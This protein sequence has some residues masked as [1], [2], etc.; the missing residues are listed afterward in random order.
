MG[1]HAART[2]STIAHVK[3]P[4]R[5]RAQTTTKMMSVSFVE[6]AATS[7]SPRLSW[8]GQGGI[9]GAA[10]AQKSSSTEEEESRPASARQDSDH[11]N[12][13]VGAKGP[14]GPPPA[15]DLKSA[16]THQPPAASD[17][18]SPG[19]N[20]WTLVQKRFNRLDRL[21]S[22]SL[23]IWG[24][25][26]DAD[27]GRLAALLRT[28][29]KCW[30]RGR[31][32]NRHMVVEFATK[33]AFSAKE[34]ATREACKAHGIKVAKSTRGWRLRRQHRPI[35]TR[36]AAKAKVPA[37]LPANRYTLIANAPTTLAEVRSVDWRRWEARRLM[38]PPPPRKPKT[39][40]EPKGRGDVRT[41][42][43]GRRKK[44]RPV[45]GSKRSRWRT[46]KAKLGGELAKN[47]TIRV[48][49][50]NVQGGMAR[51]I[52]EYEDF[53]TKNGYDVLAIQECKLAPS[54]KLAAK[55]F[56]V[57][58][59]EPEME[60]E[61]HGVLFL[62]ANHLATGVTREKSAVP[63]Q[64]WIRLTGTN[65]RKDM[66]ICSAYLPQERDAAEVR[67]HAFRALQESSKE[68]GEAGVVVVLGDLNAKIRG[69]QDAHEL[70]RMGGFCEPGKHTENGKLLMQVLLEARLVSLA[71]QSRP[72]AS[73][74]EG[75]EA[76]YWWT[77]R[78]PK[79]GILHTIDYVL[80]SEILAAGGT[81]F[82]VDYTDLNSD[83]HLVGALIECPRVLSRKRGRKTPRRRFKMDG[84]IQKSSSAADVEAA[85]KQRA[86][87]AESLGEAFTGFVLGPQRADLGDCADNGVC[88]GVGDFVSRI[89][90]AAEQ[91]VGSVE[92]GRKFSRS[93]FDDE[94]KQSIANR[95]AAHAV[96]RREGTPETWDEYERRRRA[97]NRMVK[98]KKRADWLKFEEQMEDAFHSDQRKMWQL[99]RR[100]VPSG[101]KAVVEPVLRKDGVLAK[102]EEQILE[103]WGDHQES[104][105]TP[106]PHELEDRAFGDLVCKQMR[107]AA[108]L[109]P[110]LPDTQVDREFEMEE[111]NRAVDNLDYHK[112]GTADGTVNTMF[113][114]GGEVM[115]K[116]L[117]YLFNWLRQRESIPADWQRSV[118][119][120]LFKEGDRADP[121]NYRGIALIS[122]LG[123]LYLSMWAARIAEHAE[124]RLGERQGGFRSRRSTV[125]Q[126]MTL[127][128][129]LL[130]RKRAGQDTYLCFVDFRKAF[131]T[132]WHEGLW[133]RM[134]DTGIRGK[135]WRVTRNLYSSIN[136]SVKLGDTT[137]RNVRMRQGVRQGCPL[138][139]T[140]FNLFVEELA[141][142]L[143]KSGF[144]ASIGG[145]DLESLLYADDVV[146]LAETVDNL[147][148]LIDI[149]D[150]FCRQWRME[151]NLKKSEC[152]VVR[153]RPHRCV[154]DIRTRA[155]KPAGEC[156]L[157]SPW[158]CRGQKL[159]V[160]R[161]YK[162]LGIWFTSDLLWK[163]H[164]SVMVTKAT[165]RTKSLGKVL[166]NPRLTP[167]LKTL[168][169][170]ASVRPL[171]EYGCEVW[172]ANSAQLK[173]LEAI[174]TAAGRKIFRL[175]AKTSNLAVR[176]LMQVPELRTRHDKARLNYMA[177]VMAMEK[178]RLTRTVVMLKQRDAK[179]HLGR[180]EQWLTVTNKLVDSEEHLRNSLAKLRRASARNHGVVPPGIDP[181]LMD[182]EYYPLDSWRRS[183]TWWARSLTLSSFMKARVG[184]TIDL[185]RRAVNKDD[186][187][188]PL[189]PLVRRAN[190]GP[191]QI[192]L[193]LLAGT[194]ALNA[195]LARYADKASACPFDSC[196]GELE[197]TL[198]FLL[199]CKELESLR[200]TFRERLWDRCTCD[201]RLGSGGVRGCAEFF[202]E[203]DDA[204]KALFML[205]G[206]VDNRTPEDSIDA[207]AREFVRKAWN[208]RSSTL[209]RQADAPLV[210]KPT[211]A[212]KYG[213]G[214]LITDFFKKVHERNGTQSRRPDLN[215]EVLT[216]ANPTHARSTR[217]A[218]STTG[219]AG[220][221]ANGSGL[222]DMTYVMRSK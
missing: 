197:D 119:V 143:R 1:L 103:A 25:P 170:L 11:A 120:N 61:K 19:G 117:L 9:S 142:R 222:N 74:P 2:R 215:K 217:I 23:I 81:N 123:K 139:P 200:A 34:Q 171:L 160:V 183:V 122:C 26:T 151:I 116:R 113:K 129:A 110:K 178:S 91:S 48:G 132:V 213:A 93:W 40:P 63:N 36:P 14:S 150:V 216:R 165:K 149:V 148:G 100:L 180:T 153:A 39:L 104:L 21:D 50:L 70:R 55:G 128:E 43:R 152:M 179:Q 65:G 202:E 124:L 77:R 156:V 161:K 177:K 210:G 101:K 154:C 214:R 83:H 146:L 190:W 121:G 135:A 59:Q 3:V 33:L 174:Q 68:Y 158:D 185:M 184:S 95:R 20:G 97:C 125:D 79:S 35:S 66:F 192:R 54:I 140:L 52:A 137:S 175:N 92:V 75:A 17:D 159:K 47:E 173:A 57:F 186:T 78:D 44:L 136:A 196:N 168:V 30:W 28:K 38:P 31:A 41:R 131:D 220:S 207:C 87:Y 82:W 86:R 127:H 188:M 56:K 89:M 45:A 208:I 4:A 12:E 109:S 102:S 18:A 141:Q 73:V 98:D 155:G 84:M 105:G 181:T 211:S 133:K 58:R 22:R 108:K 157:C 6:V 212:G 206:P 198:H 27:P 49:S 24:L 166:S 42:V 72:P 130:R 51:D 107:Q 172:R 64:I 15:P 114:C 37:K 99:I 145:I 134:W 46:A 163:E 219:T 138:S 112:A 53:A 71:G 167:R 76:G 203:L 187:Q 115:A 10:C 96:F 193:R 195:T 126:A 176:A 85:Q 147:Q 221:R 218:Q 8:R 199:H 205:G 204:G 62:V 209:N 60:D 7:D 162:Y 94:V 29:A 32:A 201:R 69:A 111:V 106:K 191:D 16:G 13:G 67:K 80:T 5:Y 90:R 144:G 88:L 182:F 118:I 164:I 194:S 189:F 169:W